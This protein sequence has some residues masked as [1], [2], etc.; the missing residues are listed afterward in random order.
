[1]TASDSR[2]DARIDSQVDFLASTGEMG[3][4]I[5]A[6]NWQSTPLGP[7]KSWPSS[8][9]TSVSLI[10]NSRHPMWIGWGP[11]MTF[12]YNDAYLH[13]LGAAKHG[14][15]L[16]R[17]T[18]EVW[19]E[20]WDICGPLAN[21]V[22]TDGEASF[23]DDVRLFMDRGDFLEETFYSF[24]YSPIRDESGQVCGLFCPSTDVTPKVV[25]TRRVRT[26]SQLATNALSEKTIVGA[27]ATAAN[28]LSKN[29]DDIPFALLY[30][31]DPDG[32]CALLEQ[33]V[34]YFSAGPATA[35]RVDLVLPDELHQR[36]SAVSPWPIGNVY[37]TAERQIIDARSVPGLPLAVVDQ[38]VSQVA[39]LPV[40]SRSEHQPYGVLV[41]GVNPCR[42]L[43]DDH[44]TFL[45]LVA[46]QVATA[47]QNAREIEE[48]R[49][50][51]DMLAE[52]DRA[53]TVF[54]SNVS[55]EFRTPL[56]L[57]LGPLENLLAHPEHL[58]TDDRE[59]LEIAHRNSLRL[60]KL[61]NSLLDF[62]R[63]EAGRMKA[64]YIPTELS[65][66]TADLASNFRSAMETAGL[67]LVVDCPPLPESV[68]I[69]H[70]MWEKIVLNLLS[71][72]FKFTFEGSVTV[73]L[74]ASARGSHAILTVSDTG[75]GIPES[76]LLRI[77]ERFHRIEGAKGRTYEGTGIGLALTQELVRLHG[78]DISVSSHPGEGSTFTVA[79][80]FGSAHLPED[81][82]TA[83]STHAGSTAVALPAFT[84]EAMSW[85]SDDSDKTDE[86]PKALQAGTR[87]RVLLA[88]DN[89]DMREHIARILG[90]DYELVTASDGRQALELLRR[91]PPDLLLTDIMMPGLDGFGLLRAVRSNPK[92][93]TLPVIFVSAR[94]GEEMRVEGLEAGAD[95]YLVKPFTA[96]ELRARVNAHVQMALARRRASEREAELRAEA[97]AARDHAVNVLE[98]ITDG[99]LALDGEW[100]VTFVNSE[101]ERLND[102]RRED[103]LGKSH[104]DLFPGAVGTP[105]HSELLRA[106][107]ERV[108]VDFE[109][110]YAPWDRWFH[111]KA[112]PARDGGLSVFYE[113]ITAR[114]QAEKR[115][116]ESER[117][118]REM[119]D[120]LPAAIY[121]TDADGHL[122]HYNPAAVKLSGCVPELGSDRWCITWKLFLP[123]GTPLPHDQSPMTVALRGEAT[124]D[125]AE[126]IAERPDGTR[127]WFTPYP[128]PLRDSEDR[129]VGCINMLVDVTERKNAEEALRRSEERFRG[130]FESSAVGV[131]IL[132]LNAGFLQ[133]NRA[134]CEITGYSEAQLKELDCG[135]LTHPDD[136]PAMDKL[137]GQVISGEIP[138]FVLE[139]R[140]F[141]KDGRAIWVNNSVSAMRDS[142]GW[143]EYLIALCEDVSA[144]RQA[145][146]DRRASEERFRAIVDTTPDLVKLVDSSG[147]VLLMNAS[148]VAMLG[149]KSADEIIGQN[150]C[151]VIAPEF[152]ETYRRFNEEICGGKK[153]TLEFDVVGLTGI[154]RHMETS[155]APLTGPDG[156]RVHLAI[157]RDV[158]ERKRAEAAL[159]ESEGRFR[160]L[161]EAMPQFVWTARPDG[162]LDYF[163]ERWYDFTGFSRDKLGD[164]SWQP[165]LHPA[166]LEPTV[167][168]WHQSVT[169]G[170]PYQIECR[171]RDRRENRWRWFMGRALPVRGDDGNIVK[172]FGTCTDIDEQKHVEDELR[173]ANQDLEQ[174]AYSASHDLQEPLRSIK[175]YG[176]LLTKRYGYKLDGQALEFLGYLRTG[177]TR[178]EV[179]VRDLLTYTQ[180]TRLDG[181]AETTD[182]NEVLATTLASLKGAIA[183]SDAM[184]TYDGLP[185]V[186]MHSTHLRQLFQNLIGNAIKYRNPDSRPTVHVSGERQNGSWLFSVRDNGIGIEPEYKEQVFGLFKRLHTSDE[187]SGTGIGLAICQRIVERYHGR[188]WVESEPGRG[189]TFVF[190][191]PV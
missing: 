43:D 110:C 125:G 153:G 88:D 7:I 105:V 150:A 31:A 85:L 117:N 32:R 57:M 179:L 2:I 189:A 8:L 40:T 141:T 149:A 12:L 161:A 133:A 21:K 99:F 186:R 25:N 56:T 28:T 187:Y 29:P 84:S 97:E 67:K 177:A 62:S 145:E 1:M 54:F 58:S 90:N 167:S 37:R 100:R 147:K 81:R 66:L 96:N 174:F 175:I 191:V 16:G 77:F 83:K 103:M 4:L 190:S 158:S 41:I 89:A 106:A 69:D 11:E 160:H 68:Y 3:A 79:L 154:R 156:T 126:C 44:L 53:K 182:V 30:L 70:E 171:F 102:M 55:H 168:G 60:L 122:T 129:I 143:P 94:A 118:F 61:V 18:S 140:Y 95:D 164:A 27:C 76:E 170:E 101:A 26:L 135:S 172:W 180:V 17:P 64:S 176:E 98:S 46:G 134:F 82:I 148:G 91:D 75:T 108:A 23:M 166:D 52:I 173:R 71:N 20:I 116:R 127:F 151:D 115:V 10:L 6:C 22:F 34:G 47:I 35:S 183:E 87:P 72:A 131:A 114:K 48:E 39:V 14:K 80:P 130:V 142:H 121:T 184:V 178:M 50:R 138:S 123:D 107:A 144:R 181:Q 165:V 51:A 132:T 163:N 15:S 49:K 111:V 9:K 59:H 120:A 159:L 162:Y 169:T 124:V 112:Y 45:E 157:T 13:V 188:I 63:I 24:S 74:H 139:K 104:W 109:N 152:R 78:G 136:R 137:I 33:T 93:S 65:G 146:A 113:D 128:T 86:P 73:G 155:A 92:T 42:P 36:D 19:A 5:R 38:P 185:S 119:I